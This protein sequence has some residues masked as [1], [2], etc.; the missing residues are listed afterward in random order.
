MAITSGFFNSVAGDRYYD[1]AAFAAYFASFIANGV[2]L[3][4]STNLQVTDTASMDVTVAAGK[5]WINGYIMINSGDYDLTIDAADGVYDRIDRVV[6]RFDT[7]GRVITL[8]VSKGTAGSSPV[9]PALVRDANYYELG[10]ADIAVDAGVTSIEAADIT[11]LRANSVYCGAVSSVIERP[12]P[13]SLFIFF[14]N[15]V[16]AV[17]DWAADTTHA[18]YGFRAT[19][20]LT[21]VVSTMLPYVMFSEA[22]VSTGIYGATADPYDGGIYIYAKAVPGASIT[23]PTIHCIRT[24]V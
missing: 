20:E 9:A 18:D 5:A 15:T 23:I 6:V 1:A 8:A 21:G 11:D 22:Q 2:F 16:V 7:A 14:S 10:L 4:T 12:D 24:V 17:G 13:T 3:E 19:I